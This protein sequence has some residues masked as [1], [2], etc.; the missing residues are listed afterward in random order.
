MTRDVVLVTGGDSGIGFECAR[1]LAS[2][3]RHVL[4]ASRDREASAGAVGRIV[5]E[6]GD[7]SASELGLD[8]AS[9]ASVRQ[10]WEAS[11]RMCGLAPGGSP[12]LPA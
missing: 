3:G 7:G 8:L 9:T 1:R 11:L 2:G 12:L 10:L 4:I 5:R 6:S